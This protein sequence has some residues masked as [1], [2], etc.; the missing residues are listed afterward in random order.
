MR[1]SI[2]SEQMTQYMWHLAQCC[3]SVLHCKCVR[4]AVLL[5]LSSSPQVTTSLNCMVRNTSVMET[6]IVS[7]ERIKEYTETPT[8]VKIKTKL[9]C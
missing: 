9:S 3:K 4:G 5:L 6:N 7:V 8:E 1:M 2:Q